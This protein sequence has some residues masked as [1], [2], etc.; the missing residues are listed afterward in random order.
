MEPQTGTVV[1]VISC[2]DVS[3]NRKGVY[4]QG[5]VFFQLVDTWVLAPCGCVEFGALGYRAAIFHHREG[6]VYK[7][8]NQRGFVAVRGGQTH[9][10]GD[11]EEVEGW[12]RGEAA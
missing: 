6:V 7:A 4:V 1:F 8:P 10:G 11:L 2:G 9:C 3:V 12:L 5:R